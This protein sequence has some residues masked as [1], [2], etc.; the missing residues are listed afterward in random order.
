MLV[1]L[2]GG[3]GGGVKGFGG[4]QQGARGLIFPR[5]LPGEFPVVNTAGSEMLSG[6][7]KKQA[8]VIQ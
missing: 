7:V 8:A 4:Q 5:P 6:T 1:T 2:G 3:G